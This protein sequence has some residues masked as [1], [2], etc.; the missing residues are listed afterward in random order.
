[1]PSSTKHLPK[2]LIEFGMVEYDAQPTRT[3]SECYPVLLD[4]RMIGWLHEDDA[5]QAVDK[6]RTMKVLGRNNVSTLALCA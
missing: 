1:M 2:L 4:G 6:L 5:Q 3:A